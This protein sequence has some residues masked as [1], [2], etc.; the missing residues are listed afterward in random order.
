M[1]KVNRG[2]QLYGA[3]ILRFSV[4][5]ADSAERFSNEKLHPN[6]ELD[7]FVVAGITAWSARW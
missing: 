4:R 6:Y 1:K 5:Y 3:R 2:K 7:F